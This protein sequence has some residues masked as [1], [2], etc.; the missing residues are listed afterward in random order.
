MLGIIS[1]DRRLS[2]ISSRKEL[3]AADERYAAMLVI[4]T[5]S[6]KSDANT[7]S[8]LSS[9]LFTRIILRVDTGAPSGATSREPQ[10]AD[11]HLLQLAFFHRGPA[12]AGP[13]RRRGRDKTR[14]GMT[15]IIW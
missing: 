10:S 15:V 14:R 1:S 11:S 6:P 8:L 13:R 5:A 9:Y 12:F 2:F 4:T 7:A 3:A